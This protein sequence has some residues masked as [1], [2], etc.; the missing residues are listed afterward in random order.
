MNLRR[1]LAPEPKVPKGWERGFD[2]QLNLVYYKNL[3]D[4]SVQLDHPGEEERHSPR[5]L[6]RRVFSWSRR[7]SETDETATPRSSPPAGAMNQPT[8]IPAF[9]LDRPTAPR[10]RSPA[11]DAVLLGMMV[12]PDRSP[13]TLAEW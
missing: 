10:P 8:P 4:G 12:Q 2:A 9:A 6:F 7:S 3:L 13:R 11:F 5:G 1:R